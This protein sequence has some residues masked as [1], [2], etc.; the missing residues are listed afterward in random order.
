MKREYISEAARRQ[1]VLDA[2]TDK[3]DLVE[4]IGPKTGHTNPSDQR[5]FLRYM[6]RDGLLCS[7]YVTGVVLGLPIRAEVA[8]YFKTPAARDAYAEKKGRERSDHTGQELGSR[9]QIHR[10]RV[11]QAMDDKGQFISDI[12]H[13]TGFANVQNQ[14]AFMRG[15]VSTKH[16]FQLVCSGAA[17][18]KAP[19]R[20]FSIYFKTEAAMKEFEEGYR[21]RL[22]HQQNETLRAERER[23]NAVRLAK[24][25]E[26]SAAKQ[27]AKDAERI[28][29]QERRALAKATLEAARQ[30]E[31][32]ARAESRRIAREQREALQKAERER[33]AAK[34]AMHVPRPRQ[35]VERT[36]AR[37]PAVKPKLAKPRTPTQRQADT[38]QMLT[39]MRSLEAAEFESRK[40]TAWEMQQA[41]IPPTAKITVAPTPPDRYAVAAPSA[42]GF[43]NLRPGQYAFEASTCAAKAAGGTK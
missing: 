16:V 42:G 1:D 12:G 20:R 17:I 6:V 31:R 28:E 34:K 15:M 14:R 43:S 22:K 3:G 13:L 30:A 32:E 36:P 33:K 7:C 40:R 19:R 25:A 37:A 4:V 2:I 9:T 11:L 21:S 29:R 41:I 35:P 10:E 23:A 27:A 26:A 39:R 38:A 24:R 18:G 5:R 8:V